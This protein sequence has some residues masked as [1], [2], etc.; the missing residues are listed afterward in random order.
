MSSQPRSFTLFPSLPTELRLAVWQLSHVGRVVTI[1]YDPALDRFTSSTAPPP[2]L[3]ACRESRGEALREYHRFRSR[4]RRSFGTNTTTTTESSADHDDDAPPPL[5][6]N[7][8]F[9]RELDTLYLPRPPGAL[10]YDDKH[11][12]S[13]ARWLL[14]VPKDDDDDDDDATDADADADVV[15]HLALDYV[16][17][18]ARRPWEIY[19]AHVLVR[20][21]FPRVA[22]AAAGRVSLVLNGS[23]SSAAATAAAGEPPEEEEGRGGDRTRGACGGGGRG[24]GSDRRLL[25]EPEGDPLALDVLLANVQDA[26]RYE[27]GGTAAGCFGMDEK[28]GEEEEEASVEMMKMMPPL[29]P[30]PSLVLKVMV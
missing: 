11:A 27:L 4:S 17:P 29:P 18:A 1:R 5:P 21:F 8:Y 23:S 20:S 25:A 24:G 12:T 10:G 3:H 16:P 26:F 28:E 9:S 6:D 14:V 13:V 2:A 15:A 19:Y 30:L 22:A 7:I